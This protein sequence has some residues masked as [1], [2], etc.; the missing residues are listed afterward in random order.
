MRP[1]S[2]I[3]TTLTVN[4][5]KQSPW[6]QTTWDDGEAVDHLPERWRSKKVTRGKEPAAW[7]AEQVSTFLQR[8]EGERLQGLWIVTASTGMRRSEALGLRWADVDLDEGSV[9]VRRVLVAYGKLRVTKEPKTARSRRTLPL[10]PRAVAALRFTRLRQL[11]EKLAAGP[12]WSESDLVFTD[13]IGR[14]LE[15][16]TVSAAFKRAVTAAGLPPL[17]L[18][19]LRHSFAAIGLEAGVDVLYVAEMLG[20]SSPTITQSVYQHVRRDRLNAATPQIAEA[21]DG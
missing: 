5:V 4:K 15:P 3:T 1:V 13:E 12:A 19:G 21:I 17:T 11:E 6:R 20:H 10:S 16:P 18:H 14:A 8:T 9:S 2:P 7:T